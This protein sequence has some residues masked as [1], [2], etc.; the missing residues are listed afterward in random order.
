[1]LIAWAVLDISVEYA[2]IKNDKPG[3]FYGLKA[4]MASAIAVQRWFANRLLGMQTD[5]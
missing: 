2:R 3:R 5:A 4:A 1:L